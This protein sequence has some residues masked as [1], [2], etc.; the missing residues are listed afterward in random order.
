VI[1]NSIPHRN[2]LT[3][4]LVW[5]PCRDLSRDTSR[6]HWAIIIH[7]VIELKVIR[8]LFFLVTQYAVPSN[9]EKI[10]MLMISGQGL[11]NTIW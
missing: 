3:T 9:I 1:N 4:Q 8:L 7:V 2:P 6:H 10:L 5:K 11:I